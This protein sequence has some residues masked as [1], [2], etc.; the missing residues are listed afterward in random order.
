MRVVHCKREPYDVYIGRP[1]IW[2]NPYKIGEDGTRE[3]VIEKYELYL[4]NNPDLLKRLPELS[5]KVLGCW[6]SPN[7][8]CHGEI[9]IKLI[10]E[11]EEKMAGSECEST[12]FTPD[13]I[14]QKLFEKW[15]TLGNDMMSMADRGASIVQN[16]FPE[17]YDIMDDIIVWKKDLSVA[18]KEMDERF[19]NLLALTVNYLLK[20][21]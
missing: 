4:R 1:S 21:D 20:E 18:K 3:E 6:C 12:L 17:G 5:G 9:L 8:P 16:P 10:K 7:L 2:G 11:M 13:E 14:L 19:N 15:K